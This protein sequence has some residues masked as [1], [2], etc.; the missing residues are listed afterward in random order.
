MQVCGP[1]DCAMATTCHVACTG[2]QACTRVRS[3]AAQTEI[4]CSGKEA[5]KDV[6]CAGTTCSVQC[7]DGA[8]KP[9]EVR[10][11]AKQCTV[12]GLAA[13]CN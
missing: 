7:A 11:C 2:E 8:C 4:V 9:S 5:C 6:G 12:N 13:R 10:C 3:T 1:V